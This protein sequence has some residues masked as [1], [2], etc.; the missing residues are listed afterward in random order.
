MEYV[1]GID[2]G[3][4]KTA[5]LIQPICIDEQP[6]QAGSRWITVLEKG[7]NPLSVGFGP[8]RERISTLLQ[9]AM[10]E[11]GVRPEDVRA[12]CAGLAGLQRD[13]DRLRVRMELHQLYMEL[14]LADHA[15]ITLTTDVHAALRGALPPGE[16]EGILVISGTGS[17]CIGRT[18]DGRIYRCGGWGHVL[19]DEGSGYRIG[20]MGL[21]AVCQAADA[22]GEPTMLT[23]MAVDKWH[24]KSIRDLL[25]IV[26]AGNPDKRVI[27][28]FARETL[29]CAERF[30]AVAVRIVEEAANDLVSHVR[31]LHLQSSRFSA[32]TTVTTGGSIF[33]HSPLLMRRFR[34]GIECG[35]LGVYRSGCGNAVEGAAVLAGESLDNNGMEESNLW[36]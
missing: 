24:L 27:A 19:G 32:R 3:G 1:I 5:C 14:G 28:S 11:A 8:M 7:T 16:R 20:M 13:E 25:P 15:V 4:S 9:H 18:D 10:Q 35:R 33:E 30:D 17:N 12:V 36:P 22:R 26:Y 34:E 29:V 2:G 23:A 21:Q 6:L 31:S